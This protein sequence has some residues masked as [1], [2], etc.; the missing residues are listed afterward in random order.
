MVWR[1]KRHWAAAIVLLWA[2]SGHGAQS[3]KDQLLALRGIYESELGKIKTV[4][5]AVLIPVSPC[6]VQL[7]IWRSGI[8]F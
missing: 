3:A 5:V 6:V 2:I 1:N 4:L 7:T 8:G